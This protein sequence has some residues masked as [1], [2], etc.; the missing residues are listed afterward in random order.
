MSAA[1]ETQADLT[2]DRAV[3]AAAVRGPAATAVIQVWAVLVVAGAAHVVAGT[4]A[5]CH[6][7][8]VECAAVAGGDVSREVKL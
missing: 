2:A 6:A 3:G 5:V 1:R 4:V 7:A 8:A